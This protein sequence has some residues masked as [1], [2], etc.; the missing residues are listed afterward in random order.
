MNDTAPVQETA[1]EPAILAAARTFAKVTDCRVS[2]AGAGANS[3]VYR[4]E[5]DNLA[6]ALK[7]Y[8]IRPGDTRDRQDVE[9]RALD[10]M[11]K[12][13][14]SAVPKVLAC[15][16]VGR[17]TALEWIEGA[18][19]TA[20]TDDDVA[21]ACAFVTR[22]FDLSGRDDAQDFPAASEACL[23]VGEI[24]GQIAARLDAFSSH[25][26]LNRFLDEVLRVELRAVEHRIGADRSLG[27]IPRS[28][29]R[30]IPADFGFHNALK[31]PD[32]VMR[33]FDFEY[34]GWDDP[35]KLT[36]DFILHPSVVLSSGQR[37]A[38]RERLVAAVR[39]DADFAARL[40]TT[41]PLYRIRWAL[42]LLNAFR[43][44]RADALPQ[45]PQERS[46]L[47][48]RQLEKAHAMIRAPLS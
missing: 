20:P 34:F 35:V 12:A 27:P 8:P 11:T 23:S 31:G 42:I 19:I 46:T 30:L 28:S 32:G 45:G 5:T 4:V 40:E 29:Q 17:F 26:D 39:G 43:R 9:R 25:D 14:E 48:S 2:L 44:D 18:P 33:F 47:L 10:L 13:G 16:D 22:V 6:F 36:A 21:Q 7:S 24:F 15:D 41:L 38:I 3:R 1:L 37:S